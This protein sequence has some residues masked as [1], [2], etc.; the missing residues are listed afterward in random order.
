MRYRFNN[1][2]D[3]KFVT[4]MFLLIKKVS[5]DAILIVFVSFNEKYIQEW[6]SISQ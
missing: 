6:K 3:R 4:R 1:L 5:F 2:S